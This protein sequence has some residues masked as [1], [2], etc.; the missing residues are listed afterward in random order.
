MYPTLNVLISNLTFV[1]EKFE[2]K[3]P[4]YEHFGSKLSD[5]NDVLLV[6]YDEGADFKS[7]IGFRKF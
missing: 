6:S 7:D 5:L 1:F 2:S 3:S 4:K